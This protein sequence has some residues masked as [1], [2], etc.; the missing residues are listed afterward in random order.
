MNK[1]NPGV[2]IVPNKD[3][4]PRREFVK[5]A[6]TIPIVLATIHSRTVW[7]KT[8]QTTGSACG[9]ACTSN[10]PQTIL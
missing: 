4:K 8:I 1:T 10:T 2:A 6:V 7:A 9:S 3:E 5:A